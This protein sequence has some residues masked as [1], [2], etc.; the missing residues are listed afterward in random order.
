MSSC[1]EPIIAS[2]GAALEL[3][4]KEFPQLATFQ[5]PSYNIT[6]PENGAFLK[7]KLFKNSPKFLKAIKEER[8]ATLNLVEE[9]N[10]SAIISDNRLGVF[11]KEIPSIF[12]TH[13]LNVLSGVTTW[14]STKIHNRFIKNFDFCWVPDYEGDY[15]LSGKLGHPKKF[16][17]P[18]T[19]LGPLSRFEFKNF[20]K[21][22]DLLVLLSGPEPQRDILEKQLLNELKSFEGKIVFVKGVISEEHSYEIIK[23]RIIYNFLTSDALEKVLNQSKMVLCR[24]GY[25]S[26]MDL[27]K[28]K[29][30]VFL[31]PTPGQS[32]QEYIA[33]ILSD[34]NLA[35]SCKQN[36]FKT[37]ML[38]LVDDYQGLVFED[39]HFNFKP[40]FS[41]LF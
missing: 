12:I 17:I 39:Y 30:K 20:P 15:N 1:Y 18:T 13:Q 9:Y 8:K 36:E 38:N 10:I 28:L 4:K 5:L 29:K 7:I 22:Y 19:Y 3:L 24:S 25:T 26:I 11:S 23:N 40:L 31:I 6:Y 34:K 41:C 14:L 16:P 21:K 33:K 32:E 37:E 2:D 35:P 27:A